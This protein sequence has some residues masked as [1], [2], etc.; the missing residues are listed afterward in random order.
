MGLAQYADDG[1][2]APKKIADAFRTTSEEIARTAGLGKDAVQRR[3]RVRSD[4][5]QRRLREMVEIVN[6]VESRFGSA[7]MAYAWYRS[8]PLPGFSGRTAMQLVR[9]GRADEVLD[10]I[11]AVDAGVY[12]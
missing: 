5:T 6:K 10:F 1:L 12:A 4:K 7:L 3:E 2:F 9:E 8:E 11:D